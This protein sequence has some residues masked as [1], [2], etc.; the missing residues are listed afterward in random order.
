MVKKIDKFPALLEL[1]FQQ[2]KAE[3]KYIYIK[4][5]LSDDG[6]DYEEN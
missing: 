3:N 4:A 6:K 2:R 1:K 5:N